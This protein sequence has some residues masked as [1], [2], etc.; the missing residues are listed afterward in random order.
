MKFKDALKALESGA[1]IARPD[2]SATGLPIYRTVL[3]LSTSVP[4]LEVGGEWKLYK[5]P[6]VYD[7]LHLPPGSPCVFSDAEVGADDWEV[8]A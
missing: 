5:V 1:R 8:V 4:F 2:A 3:E 7:A 6:V